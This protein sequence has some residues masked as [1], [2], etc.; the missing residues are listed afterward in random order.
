MKKVTLALLVLALCVPAA[1]KVTVSMSHPATGANYNQVTVSYDCNEGEE[2][3][4]FALTISVSDGGFLM[5]S[6]EFASDPNTADYYVSPSSMLFDV[7]GGGVTYISSFGHPVAEQDANGGILEVASLYAAADSN[8]P[9]AP[10]PTGNLCKFRVIS[11]N[12]GPDNQVQVTLGLDA[13]RGG[14]VLV[15][16]NDEPDV[17]LEGPLTFDYCC[18]L[19]PGQALGDTNGSGN[20]NAMD[21]LAVKNAWLTNSAGS[22]H[23]T[24]KG[25]YNCCADFNHSLNVNAFDLLIVKNNWLKSGLG[26]CGNKYCP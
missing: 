12:C 6:D 21:L 2:V 8:H 26:T 20:I 9:S 18:W 23:G 25:Q 3:R 24:L 10:G 17:V 19:C 15:D 22:P 4:A 14:I 13:Q 16:P 1:A 7:N 11:Q 5:D